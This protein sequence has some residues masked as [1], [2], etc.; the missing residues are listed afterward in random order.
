MQPWKSLLADLCMYRFN[1]SDQAG[2]AV[3]LPWSRFS[4]PSVKSRAMA[5]SMGFREVLAVR[6]R[7]SPPPHYILKDFLIPRCV[8]VCCIFH[9]GSDP[10]FLN[11]QFLCKYLN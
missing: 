3:G 6:L 8:D 11:L 4:E 1:E 2:A 10:V 5:S 7:C 9:H